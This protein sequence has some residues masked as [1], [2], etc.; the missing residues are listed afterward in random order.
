MELLE[1]YSTVT[2]VGLYELFQGKTYP[3]QHGDWHHGFHSKLHFDEHEQYN[4]KCT[5]AVKHKLPVS[6]TFVYEPQRRKCTYLA[7]INPHIPAL[8]LHQLIFSPGSANF[9][10]TVSPTNRLPRLNTSVNGPAQS[11]R[12]SFCDMGVLEW[13]DSR[14]EGGSRTLR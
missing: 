6:A 9:S 14:K 3:L 10:P 5:S 2:Q 11:I 1:D 7:P 12:L 8:P 13:E 4:E